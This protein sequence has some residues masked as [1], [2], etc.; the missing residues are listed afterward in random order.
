MWQVAQRQLRSQ[1]TWERSDSPLLAMYCTNVVLARDA[2]ARAENCSASELPSALKTV[3]NA[4]GAALALA[5]ALLLTPES[6]RR[7]HVKAPTKG[8]ED[9]LQALIG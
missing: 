7:N 2:R 6:R 9:E 5:K 8:I 1:G 3:S 4:E